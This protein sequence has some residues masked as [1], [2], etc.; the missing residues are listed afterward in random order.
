MFAAGSSSF[1]CRSRL[2]CERLFSTFLIIGKP[3]GGKGTVSSKIVNSRSDFFHLS[4]GDALRE[5]VRKGSKLGL[6]A[7]GI[8]DKGQ[9]LSDDVM[10]DLVKGKVDGVDTDSFHVLLDGFP[11]T[12]EQAKV[13]C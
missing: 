12:M 6:K 10:V 11:R 5:E 4:T 3:G 7:K 9:L 1:V 13:R 8:M 2:T